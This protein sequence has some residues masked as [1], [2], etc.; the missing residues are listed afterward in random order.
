MAAHL[1]VWWS[2]RPLRRGDIGSEIQRVTVIFGGAAHLSTGSTGTSPD[3]R[4]PGV[5]RNAP[6]R[7]TKPQEAE[8]GGSGASSQPQAFPDGVGVSL[9]KSLGPVIC[10]TGPPACPWAA[11]YPEG[12]DSVM[13]RGLACLSRAHPF[14]PGGV[15]NPI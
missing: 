11:L 8:S 1:W 15:Q 7:M 4:T 10:R 14:S 3:G 9:P 13:Q 2:G 6:A 12:P 5:S